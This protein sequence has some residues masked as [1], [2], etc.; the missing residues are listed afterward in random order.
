M[1]VY[2][3]DQS[4]ISGSSP[5]WVER[6]LTVKPPATVVL[7]STTLNSCFISRSIRSNSTGLLWHDPIFGVGGAVIELENG[8][9]VRACGACA[10]VGRWAGVEAA[11]RIESDGERAGGYRLS[12][13][14]G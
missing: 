1:P 10:S 14:G 12:R 13:G 6:V 3:I 9:I 11:T 7:E 5:A 8:A 4:G 2:G